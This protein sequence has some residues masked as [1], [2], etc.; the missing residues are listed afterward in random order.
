MFIH[1]NECTDL[2]TWG[3]YHRKLRDRWFPQ[4]VLHS[5]DECCSMRSDMETVWYQVLVKHRILV[6]SL[7]QSIMNQLVHCRT[8]ANKKKKIIMTGTKKFHIAYIGVSLP[9]VWY[10]RT[11]VWQ[12]CLYEVGAEFQL[13]QAFGTFVEREMSFPLISS[14]PIKWQNVTWHIKCRF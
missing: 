14:L 13:T 6:C 4:T 5:R 7:A 12:V 2:K 8:C 3:S 9:V 10:G 11:S 1:E